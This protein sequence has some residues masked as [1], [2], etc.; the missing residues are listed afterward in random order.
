MPCTRSRREIRL[1]SYRGKTPTFCVFPVFGVHM[2]V[3]EKCCDACCDVE[4]YFRSS[5]PASH[6]DGVSGACAVYDRKSTGHT[7]G[8]L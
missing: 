5:F 2:A 3:I 8:E 7:L 1:V 4:Y 6:G